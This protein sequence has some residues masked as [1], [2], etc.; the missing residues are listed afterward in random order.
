MSEPQMPEI[1]M[2]ADDLFLEEA[3]TDNR[4]GTIRRMT[5]VDADGNAD[6]SRP[7][8]FL[9]STQIMTPAGALPISFEIPASNLKE[10]AEKFGEEAQQALEKT[11][12][13]LQEMR[14]QA[15]SSIVVPKGGSGMDGQG[16]PAGGGIQMP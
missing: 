14:R 4:T 1:S 7:V 11:M 13:E 5:P 9:G 3:F 15:A 16:G 2:N 12:E 8:T 10:A 6:S